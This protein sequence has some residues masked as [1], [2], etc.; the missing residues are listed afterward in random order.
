MDI[1]CTW[2]NLV[3]NTLSRASLVQQTLPNF[4]FCISDEWESEDI[5]HIVNQVVGYDSR[6]ARLSLQSEGRAQALGE[7]AV[8]VASR[9]D[10]RFQQ[11]LE[12]AV[13]VAIALPKRV[14]N[15]VDDDIN[16]RAICSIAVKFAEA[17]T[18]T[19]IRLVRLIDKSKY[20]AMALVGIAERLVDDNPSLTKSLL[21]QAAEISDRID[22]SFRKSTVL[23]K[24]AGVFGRVD[25]EQAR[26]LIDQISAPSGKARGLAELARQVAATDKQLAR[27]FFDLAIE[28]AQQIPPWPLSYDAKVEVLTH[29]AKYLAEVGMP[30]ARQVYQQAFE[31]SQCLPEHPDCLRSL[32]MS[33]LVES[34]AESYLDWA[35]EV[36]RQVPDC[37]YR[38][39]SIAT[40]SAVLAKHDANHALELAI[41]V[42][43]H[44][45][46]ARVLPTIVRHMFHQ[47]DDRAERAFS[48][49][50]IY[51]VD[52]VFRAI[53][54]M[55]PDI[56]HWGGGGLVWKTYEVIVLSEGRI[57]Q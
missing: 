47:C 4:R 45:E 49:L 5:D 7:I 21:E 54:Q 3:R 37:D 10:P 43:D 33:S 23:E 27:P 26:Q 52:P 46:Q 28:A 22:S 42:K 29:I 11:V 2:P 17:D 24:L 18:D 9:Q 40:I 32:A 55:V 53:A 50:C 48:C 19:A 15:F 20:Q 13:D 36:A 12:H 14:H 39:K 51:G 44:F 25:M 34:A 8:W 6:E 16:A 31:T 41:S 1:T 35:H 56:G 38:A 30:D 57:M